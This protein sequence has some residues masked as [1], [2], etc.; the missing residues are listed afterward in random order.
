MERRYVGRHL[1]PAAPWRYDGV[2]PA[3]RLPAPVLGEHSD[4]VLGRMH[5]DVRA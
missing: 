4:E 5:V 1:M 2:R 3:L